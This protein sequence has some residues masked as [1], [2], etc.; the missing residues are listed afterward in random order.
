MTGTERETGR[1]RKREK[2]R[3]KKNDPRDVPNRQ[4]MT[5]QCSEC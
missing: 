5:E 2:A 4:W 1:E 3:G